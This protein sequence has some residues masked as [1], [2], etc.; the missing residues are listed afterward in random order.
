MFG[1]GPS[2][3]RGDLDRNAT[4]R[5]A[6]SD[7]RLTFSEKFFQGDIK[8]KLI[9]LLSL[10]VEASKIALSCLLAI[11]VPQGCPGVIDSPNPALT[12][13]HICTTQENFEQLDSFNTFVVV[14]N[15]ACVGFMLFHYNSVWRRERF[16]IEYLDENPSL[17]FQNLQN[18]LS[19]YPALDEKFGHH[20]RVVLFTSTFGMLMLLIN[21][22]AS[23]V[24][25]FQYFYGGYTT[26]TVF[27]TNVS[28]LG[29]V[30]YVAFSNSYK[31]IIQQQAFSCI[32][33]TPYF[34][35]SLDPLY[36]KAIGH[37]DDFVGAE[38]P[39]SG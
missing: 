9:D 19:K 5:L 13:P 14:W 32:N 25:V 23:G 39:A 30:V 38:K 34:F 7:N 37:K 35:N 33:F 20:N 15:F 11:F 36:A 29:N 6:K 2:N 22:L 3:A 8:Q 18:I 28:L 12:V 26:I 17:P 10:A 31:G 16:L 1:Q 24:L 27:L 21:V 4:L